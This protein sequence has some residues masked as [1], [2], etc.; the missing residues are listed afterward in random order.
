[1][2]AAPANATEIDP[3]YFRPTEV[4]Y[5][6]GDASRAQKALGWRAETPFRQLVAMMVDHDHALAKREKM[7]KEA[8]HTV[9]AR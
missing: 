8:G 5:L 2:N 7:L 1:M 4:D 9:G 3:R 6:L